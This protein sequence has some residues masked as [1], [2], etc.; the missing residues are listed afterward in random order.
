MQAL[1]GISFLCLIGASLLVGTRLLLLARRTRQLPETVLG[2][3][4]VVTMGIA[5]P[6]M[7]LLEADLGWSSATQRAVM[8]ALNVLID[9]GFLLLFVFTATVFRPGAAIGKAAIAA[10]A[11]A[12]L[13]HLVLVA[14]VLSAAAD[15]EAARAATT[16]IGML[17]LGT[18][19]LGYAWSGTE[20]FTH[21]RRL[22][23]QQRLGLVDPVLCDRM[24]LWSMMSLASLAGSAANMIYLGLGI[25]VLTRPD[26]MFITSLTGLAQGVFLWLTFLPPAFYRAT[27]A[28][29]AAQ[30]AD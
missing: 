4:L 9:A 2:L 28:R 7:I 19:S 13:V 1:A 14:R 5:Y 20:S 3:S 11:T 29:R 15:L 30:A 18:A 6:G 8:L 16:G 23:R 22:V 24:W 10:A 27:I 25:D 26:A 12:F 17:A 21:W